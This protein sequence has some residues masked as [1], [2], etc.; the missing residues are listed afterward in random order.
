MIKWSL[1][2]SQLAIKPLDRLAGRQPTIL[3]FTDTEINEWIRLACTTGNG[4]IFSVTLDPNNWRGVRSRFG[5]ILLKSDTQMRSAN[6]SESSLALHR[7]AAK[8]KQDEL[9]VDEWA[10]DQFAVIWYYWEVMK[11]EKWLNEQRIL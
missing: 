3:D 2:E 5:L 10:K 1:A 7:S 11:I 4:D 9:L 8:N 6:G